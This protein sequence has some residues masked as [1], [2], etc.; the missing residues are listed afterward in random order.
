MKS[1]LLF[2]FVFVLLGSVQAR[3]TTKVRKKFLVFGLSANSYKGSLQ[4]GYARWTPS[5]QLGLRFE[6]NKNVNG[7]ISLCFGSVV[8][9]DRLYQIPAKADPS[10]TPVNRF[11]TNFFGL[12]YEGQ[13][14]LFRYHGLKVY[15]SLGLGLFRFS[16]KDWDGNSLFE[17]D[18]TREKNESYSEVT[19]FR[20]TKIGFQYRF[21]NEM[22]LGM[23]GGWLNPSTAYLDNMNKLSNNKTRDNIAVFHFQFFYPIR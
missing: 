16:V 6:K 19:I 5:Y 11:R 18:R 8:G 7:M 4:S 14:I 20:P 22:S 13:L 2:L 10:V 1:G 21:K 17:K 15:A 23:Q 3:D 12:G 9:E